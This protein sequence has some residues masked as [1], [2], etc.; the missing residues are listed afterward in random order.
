MATTQENRFLQATV[1]S[2]KK[3]TLLLHKIF[4]QEEFSKPFSYQLEF[5]S[6][7]K[8]IKADD[9]ITR[10]I[11]FSL[12]SDGKQH[13]LHGRIAAFAASAFKASENYYLYKATVV[14]W[15]WLLK[16][17]VN[18]QIFQ[19]KNLKDIIGG[20][21][22]AAGFQDFDFSGIHN[23][24]TLDYCVQ[25]DES[26]FD[27]VSRL[28]E[29][30]GIFY[31]FKHEQ[32]K[33]TLILADQK[34]AYGA[35]KQEVLKRCDFGQKGGAEIY[36]WQHVY[37][38]CSGKWTCNSHDFLQPNNSLIADKDSIL[39][40]ANIKN[41]EIY[42]YSNKYLKRDQGEQLSRLRL[43]AEEAQYSLVSGQ[44][45]Y[46]TFYVGDKMRLDKKFFPNEDCEEFI[47]TS[48]AIEA[49]E[50]SY[51]PSGESINRTP[52]IN[53]FTCAPAN[54]VFRPLQQTLK[55]AIHGVQEATIS[56]PKGESI[57]TDKYGRYKVKFYWD[58][59]LEKKEDENCSCWMRALKSWEGLLR[60]GTPVLVGFIDDDIDKPI[61][62]GLVHDNEQKPLF[63]LPANKTRSSLRRRG[64][65]NGDEKKYNEI[66][67][68]DK[69]DKEQFI[70]N[71]SKD[72]L[73]AVKNDRTVELK[74]GNDVLNINKGALTITLKEG[75]YF[76]N[77]QKG[78][79]EIASKANV[80]IHAGGNLSLKADNEVNIEAG[81]LSIKSKQ[82]LDI[83]SGAA[84]QLE[85]RTGAQ[86]KA[87]TGLQ[88]ESTAGMTHKAGTSLDISSNATVN[89]QGA[90]STL[91]SSGVSKIEGSLVK[92]S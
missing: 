30:N 12:T 9:I 10:P 51:L 69:P 88:L 57:Y 45:S 37:N 25:Y 34:S 50:R 2:L 32:N 35:P 44:S 77:A 20:I 60:V 52:Y 73:V 59:N 92:V 89:I 55:P 41:Y 76:L 29:E 80:Y 6:E 23:N 61:I 11:S 17:R 39:T 75:K 36:E 33:H 68:E 27:F 65:K 47:I 83:N 63:E 91:K 19:T 21:F 49:I 48:L 58:R 38:F 78:D 86:L 14:P 3:D 82:A 71:A 70:E 66:I 31:F 13:Y 56:G 72:M 16:K 7:T 79:I 54:I 18:S 22:K 74:E 43:E 28:L 85:S 5:L 24:P 15:F 4:G 81:S 67:F 87:G 1:G 64:G 8:G 40:I 46:A 42:D 90:M 26:D 62:L 84:L 53:T